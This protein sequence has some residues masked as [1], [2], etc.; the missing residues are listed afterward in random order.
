MMYSMVLLT[1]D[2]PHH[3][4]FTREIC[5]SANLLEI[6]VE[7][8]QT[9]PRFDTAHP[10][11][12]RRDEYEREVL[13]DGERAELSE[14]AR[15]RHADRANDAAVVKMLKERAPQIIATFGTRLLKSEVISAASVACVNLHGGDPRHYRGLDSHL[16]AIYHGDFDGLVT[17]LHHV[18]LE[19]DNGDL[20]DQK[21]IPIRRGMELYQLRSENTKVCV[22]LVKRLLASQAEI[23]RSAQKSRGR[24]YSFMPVCLKDLCVERFR[25]Y[26]GSI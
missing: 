6:V 3:R 17:A 25:N 23:Q 9:K 8:S 26:A 15:V 10:Y 14:F 12:T 11:E 2:T 20:I 7:T 4:Y 18:D 16:W 21:P 19:L 22:D 5:R 13:L 1:T 24:Y